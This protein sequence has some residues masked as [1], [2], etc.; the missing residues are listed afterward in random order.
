MITFLSLLQHKV[1]NNRKRYKRVA[2][3]RSSQISIVKKKKYKN[4][5]I[6]KKRRKE[7]LIG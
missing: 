6:R 4:K 1:Y 7:G 2:V 5:A 3:R